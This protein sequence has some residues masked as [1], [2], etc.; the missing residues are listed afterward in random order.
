MDG[1]NLSCSL[2]Q[3]SGDL[4][5]GVPFNIASASLMTHIFAKLT[6]KK[7]YELVHKLGRYIYKNHIDAIEEQLTRNPVP[8]P[9]LDI[10]NRP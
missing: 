2:Y 9:M 3:R 4:G 6:G 5:L 8:F 1:D 7:A 10:K